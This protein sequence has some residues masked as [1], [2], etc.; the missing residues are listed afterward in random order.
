LDQNVVIAALTA[1]LDD[2]Y[3]AIMVQLPN[4]DDEHEQALNHVWQ[5]LTEVGL[6]RRPLTKIQLSPAFKKFSLTKEATV[7]STRFTTHGGHVDL[8]ATLSEG[9]IDDVEAVRN[10]RRGVEDAS[11]ATADGMFSFSAEKYEQL[12]RTIK[13]EGYGSESRLRIWVQCKREDVYT[14][15]SVIWKNNTP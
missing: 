13:M 9:G 12:S 15:L 1:A 7:K 10:V 4:E 11:F 14:V 8:V 5:D 2:P 3:C 6:V